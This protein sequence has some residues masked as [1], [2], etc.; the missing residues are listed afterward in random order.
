[1]IR[2]SEITKPP[3]FTQ[4]TD[5]QY[6]NVPKRAWAVV[7]FWVEGAWRYLLSE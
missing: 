3:I 4:L 7:L 2:L 1:M 5:K 6:V